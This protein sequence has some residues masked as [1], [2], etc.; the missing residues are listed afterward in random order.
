[1]VEKNKQ[2]KPIKVGISSCLL[3]E[4][5]RFDG[6]HKKSNYIVHILGHF[7]K[8]VM[9]CP[10]LEIGMGVPREAVKLEGD[11]ESPRMVGN[12]SGIDW[13]RKMN[14]YSDRR[15]R[16][17]ENYGLSGY[18]LKKDSP[19]CGMER[20]RVYGLK[21]APAKKGCGLFARVLMERFPYLPIEEEGRL[22][23]L[24]LREN[25]V[26]RVFAYHRLRNMLENQFSRRSL[27]EFHTR[28]KYLLMAHCPQHYRRLGQTV[29]A[30]KEHKPAELREIYGNTY[31]QALQIKTTTKKNVNVL[32]HMMGFLKKDLTSEEKND[33]LSVIEDYRNQLVPLIV[34]IT[35]VKHYLK[36]CKVD[37]V[38]NQIYLSPSP[39]EL[40]LRNHV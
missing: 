17:I 23:D 15:T 39:K 30:A 13:T 9:I 10:E 19:S 37:Y 6:G 18:I 2:E 38:L 14:A 28:E 33:I 22:N 27:V 24:V 11:P 40:M 25:F 35:L 26:V 29:A 3:G 20:V 8:F 36:K 5:V 32:H 12:K 7:F 16:Q 1:M 34:P 4:E 31:M 21:G